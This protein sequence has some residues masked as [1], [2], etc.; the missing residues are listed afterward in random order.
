MVEEARGEELGKIPSTSLLGQE[1]TMANKKTHKEKAQKEKAQKALEKAWE[2]GNRAIEKAHKAFETW[3]T[4]IIRDYHSIWKVREAAAQ[5]NVATAMAEL[6]F[7]EME[8]CEAAVRC[9]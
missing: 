8:Y 3:E 1:I 5:I 2:D 4:A 7:E 6:A 9:S